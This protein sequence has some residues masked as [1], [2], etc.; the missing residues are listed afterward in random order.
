MGGFFHPEFRRDDQKACMTLSRRDGKEDRRVKANKP[1][2]LEDLQRSLA[3]GRAMSCI[4]STGKEEDKSAGIQS[5]RNTRI[6]QSLLKSFPSSLSQ[7]RTDYDE[8]TESSVRPKKAYSLFDQT[9]GDEL[10]MDDLFVSPTLGPISALETKALPAP[11]CSLRIDLSKQ[12][13]PRPSVQRFPEDIKSTNMSLWSSSQLMTCDTNNDPFHVEP[14][15]IEEMLQ[16]F[17]EDGKNPFPTSS[18][19][20]PD[21]FAEN[22]FQMME[23]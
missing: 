9:F 4:G 20:G 8:L 18:F 23:T 17:Q 22:S 7:D 12:L 6:P 10:D 21:H 15:S 5:V 11:P 16:T 14:R 3:R 13:P 1:K 2:M 19:F